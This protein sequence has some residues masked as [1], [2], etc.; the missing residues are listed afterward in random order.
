[1]PAELLV[2]VPVLSNGVNCLITLA[3][4]LAFSALMGVNMLWAIALLPVLVAIQFA[5]T[6]GVSLIVA[7]MNVFYR[8]LQQIVSYVMTAGFFLTPIFFSRAA[9]PANLQFIVTYNP[10]G[11]LISAYQAVLYRGVL[12]NAGDVIFAAA[13]AL[14]CLA[15]GLTYFNSTRDSFG[16]FV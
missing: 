12:P 6:L 2:L 13:F 8:D 15:A 7:S 10:L 1:M 16:E 5:I 11:G 9:I 3:M 4:L 14:T